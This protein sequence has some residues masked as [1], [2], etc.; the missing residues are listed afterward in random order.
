[1][2][3]GRTAQGEVAVRALIS[4][5]TVYPVRL[6]SGA[7]LERAAACVYLLPLIGVLAGAPGALALL[8]SGY[9]LPAGV[10]ASLG[11]AA[12]LLAAGFHHT[13]GLLDVGDAL[14]VRSS[15]ARRREVMKD[16]SVG[17]GGI[18]A[19]LVVYA[20][21]FAALAALA[22]ASPVLAACALLAAE[23]ASRS[24][25]LLILAFGKPAEASSSSSPFIEALRSGGRRYLG[26]ALAAVLPVFFALP[27]GIFS[28]AALL[29]LP[30]AVG[31]LFV[32]G[33]AFGGVGGDVSG[34]SGEAARTVALVAL[35]AGV[36]V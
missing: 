27:L 33:R 4:F 19:L 1:M 31:A 10:A 5:F 23:T 20:P 18:G 36:A 30:V 24:T 26:L 7:T 12:V 3:G 14:M 9:A 15:P 25:M 22:G 2:R 28:L 16:L 13:D 34:A 17:V 29:W 8:L 6:S 11:L 21:A 35:S 32:A